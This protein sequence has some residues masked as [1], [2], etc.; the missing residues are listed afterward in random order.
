M[1]TIED[2]SKKYHGNYAIKNIDFKVEDKE[3][4][5][6]VGPSGSGKTTLLRC[7]NRLEVPTSG[8]VYIS[9]IKITGRNINKLRPKIGMVF[10]NFNLFPHMKIMENLIYAPMQ[11]LGMKKEAADLKAQNLLKKFGMENK[12]N[13]KP[14]DLSGGQKQ[15]IAI[16]R[17]LMMN[18]E[19]ILFD[20]PTSA[21]DPEVVQDIVDVIKSL[22]SE[23]TVIVVTHHIKF[24]KAIAD[25]IIFMDQG[26]VLC[27]QNTAE[28][29]A[30]PKSHR[31]RLFLEK[32]KDF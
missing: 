5:A 19:L 30:K 16:I 18:P 23:M 29:F 22:K 13:S 28:F 1:I 24:A 9:D 17:S 12:A 8:H 3:V 4:V 2:L 26:Q 21:L 15:R 25:R 14:N 31:A 32:V 10:Q 7:I 11:V 6:I 27:N 20:E